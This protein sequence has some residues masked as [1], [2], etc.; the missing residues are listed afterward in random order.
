MTTWGIED[1][2]STALYIVFHTDLDLKENLLKTCFDVKKHLQWTALVPATMAPCLVQQGAVRC[3][4]PYCAYIIYVILK[5]S[6]AKCMTNPLLII[7]KRFIKSPFPHDLC[8]W[9]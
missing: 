8:K 4:A 3:C 7:M 2:S 9:C 5:T 6:S 1:K